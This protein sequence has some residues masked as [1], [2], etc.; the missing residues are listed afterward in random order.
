MHLTLIMTRMVFALSHDTLLDVD[1]AVK[2]RY[3]QCIQTSNVKFA[4]WL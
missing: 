3:V 1:L 2:W 4:R